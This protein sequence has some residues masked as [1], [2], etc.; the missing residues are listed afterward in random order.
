[1]KR[2]EPIWETDY[3]ADR[4]KHRHRCF[5]CSRVLKAGDRAV[6]VRV[7]GRKTRAVHATCAD[8]QHAP[9]SP[10]TTREIM[11]EWGLSYLK[12][13]GWAVPELTSSN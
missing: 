9:D 7:V 6:M 12:S 4:R 1:M 5:C 8:R 11:R 2:P 13:C 3:S 10:H